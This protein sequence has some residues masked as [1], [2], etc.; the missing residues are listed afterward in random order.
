MAVIAGIEFHKVKQPLKHPFITVLQ[1]VEK[2]EGTV[3]IVRDLEGREGYGE[4][5]AFD[6]PWYTEE[7]VTGSRFVME[8]V[9]ALS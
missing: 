7:T 6:T 5:V 2:R 4:C 9:L 1:K 8:Q 3:V